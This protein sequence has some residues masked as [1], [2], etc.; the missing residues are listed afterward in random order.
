M[1]NYDP[2]KPSKYIQYP[3]KNN[4]YGWGI[5]GFFPYGGFKWLKNVYNFDVNSVNEDSSICYI[6]KVDLKYPDESHKLHND[7]PLAPERIAIPYDTLSDFCKKIADGYGIKLGAV[8]KLIP[9]LGGKTNHI[10]H[11]RSLQFYLSLGMKMTKIHRVLK[12]KQPDW[13]KFHMNFNTEKRKKC[14]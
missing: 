9:N 5:S 12:F 2:A 3:D 10:V 1:K 14:C 4:F 7:Y 6:L 8:K 13:M 11:Y